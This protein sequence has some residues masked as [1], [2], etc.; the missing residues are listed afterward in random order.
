MAALTWTLAG[1]VV[2]ETPFSQAFVDDIKF[3]I[4]R[5]HRSWDPEDKTWQ[6]D[7]Y[8]ADTAADI[9]FEHFPNGLEY[10]AGEVRPSRPTQNLPPWCE[11]LHVLP[12]APTSVIEAAYRALAKE[13]HPDTG[14]GE[15]RR[16]AQLN[17]A[18]EEAR[19]SRLIGGS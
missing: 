10:E 9:F 2:L 15:T 12:T 1:G 4:P 19:K 8:Y 5:Q 7:R 16:M 14:N 6:V 11:E 17:L 13:R 3:S 18:V